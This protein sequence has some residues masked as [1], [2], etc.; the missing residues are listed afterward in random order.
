MTDE[1]TYL[2]AFMIGLLGSTHCIGMCGGIVGALTMGLPDTDR[3]SIKQLLPYL[4][5]YNGGRLISYMLAGLIIA[6]I[7]VSAGH[8]VQPGK[9]PVG[10]IIGGLFMLALGIYIGG[11]FQ[12]MAPLEKLGSHFWRLIEPVGRRLLPVTS[13]SKAFSLGFIWGWLPCGLVYSTL[14]LAAT[15]ADLVKTPMLMLAFGL[16]TLPLLLAMGGLAEKLQRFTRNRWTRYVAGALLVLFGLFILFRATS[17][18]LGMGAP[19]NHQHMDHQPM[20]HQSMQHQ[21]M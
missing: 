14:A 9:L 19:M 6:I 20:N 2:A 18:M 12:T 7:A 10:G 15:A 21:S 5:L 17:M 3:R 16:G 8:L 11:W 13:Y 4:L 1:L